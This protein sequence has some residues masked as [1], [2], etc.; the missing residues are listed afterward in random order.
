MFSW[1]KLKEVT[2]VSKGWSQAAGDEEI[3][4]RGEE[5]ESEKTNHLLR[6]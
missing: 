5:M 4:Q 6:N 3:V 1:K 2:K